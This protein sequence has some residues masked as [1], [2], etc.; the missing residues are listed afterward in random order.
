MNKKGIWIPIDLI[1]D[2]KLDWANKA[3]LSEIYSLAN[4]ENG[5]IAS[6]QHFAQLLGVN[7]SAASKRVTKLE[8]LGY[9]TCANQYKNRL[10]I[11]RVITKVT[12]H[13]NNTVVPKEQKGSSDNT[14]S[15]VPTEPEPSS[16]EKPI[17]TVTNSGLKD[18]ISIHNTG[19][20]NLLGN[21]ISKTYKSQLDALEENFAKTLVNLLDATSIGEEIFDYSDPDKFPKLKEKIGKE[22]FKR[23]EPD[24]LNYINVRKQLGK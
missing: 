13:R 5:C 2:K 10:C 21:S 12:S 11:G 24:L 3:L 1:N 14:K 20:N 16:L 15:V 22:E 19:T 17:N 23:I 7:K 9:I 18:Q 4:L 6:N 8:K